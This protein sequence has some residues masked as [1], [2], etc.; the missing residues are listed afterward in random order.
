MLQHFMQAEDSKEDC[1][2]CEIA[3]T[4]GGKYLTCQK[5]LVQSQWSPMMP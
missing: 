1:K 5:I 3:G 2:K 4:L